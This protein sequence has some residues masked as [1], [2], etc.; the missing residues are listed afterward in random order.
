MQPNIDE[1]EGSTLISRMQLPDGTLIGIPAMISSSSRRRSIGWRRKASSDTAS[2]VTRVTSSCQPLDS[3]AAASDTLDSHEVHLAELPSANSGTACP[4]PPL[5]VEEDSPHK[6]ARCVI[7]PAEPH[8]QS[9]S[10]EHAR[11]FEEFLNRQRSGVFRIAPR[12][13]G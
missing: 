8:A 2:I 3:V 10:I 5:Y 13:S 7:Q 9:P 6:D 11:S 4:H 1:V 12:P